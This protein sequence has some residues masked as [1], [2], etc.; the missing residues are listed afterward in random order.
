MHSYKSFSITIG[1]IFILFL[2]N[3]VWAQTIFKGQVINEK[4]LAPLPGAHVVVTGTTEGTITNY[5]G[6]YKLQPSTKRDSITVSFV[7]FLSKTKKLQ[8]DMVI[9]LQPSE[10]ELDK[11][12]V[13]ASR[14][15]QER[16][17]APIAISTISEKTINETKPTTPREVLNKVSGVYMVDLGNEQHSMGMRQPLSY[18]SMFLYLEDGIPIRPTGIFNH[19]ALIEMNMASTSRMEVIKGP[20]SSLYGSEAIGGAI[21]F[22]THRPT[23]DPE[24][25]AQLQGNNLNYKRADLKVSDSWGKVG[26]VAS[27]YYANRTE[28]PRD[29]S[30]FDKLALTIRADW[31][32]TDKTVWTNSLSYIDYKTDM[33]GGVDSTNFFSQDFTS[34]QTFTYRK[35]DALRLRSTVDQFWNPSSKTSITGIYRDNAM[36]QNPHYRIKDDYKPWS[37]TGDPTLA[38]GEENLNSFQSLGVIAQHREQLEFLNTEWITGVSID[39]SPND[40][41]A[42]YI[43]IDKNSEGIYTNYMKTDSLLTKYSID[44]MNTAAYTHLKITPIE[45]LK[46]IASLRYDRIDYDYDNHLNP[47]A[48]SGAPDEKNNFDQ[49]TPKVGLTYDLGNKIG[50]YSN[51]SVGF[52]PPEVSELYRGVKVPTLEPSTYSNYELGGWLSFAKNKGY[53]DLSIYQ[54]NGMNEIIS[55]KQ[56]DGSTEKENAGETRH[57]GVEYTIRYAPIDEV[58]FRVSGANAE[59]EFI[60]FVEEGNDYSGNLM[61]TAPSF[62]ANSEVIYRPEFLDGAHV[63]LEWQHMSEYYMDPANT[64]KYPGFDVFNLRLGYEVSGIEFW[65]HTLNMTDKNYATIVNKSAWGKSYRVGQPRTFTIGINYNFGGG[66]D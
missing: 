38:H 61:S 18:D 21:N 16:S 63:G 8:K 33:T 44:L 37:D 32:V 60:D 56:P 26:V 14:D 31:H 41:K 10:T 36:G 54:L 64:E 48:F 25:Q 29:H 51:Y 58:S 27:G 47:T 13:T 55:V 35:V 65:V 22:I 49:V 45:K 43:Q 4:T 59:H 9:P 53:M 23:R 62:I 2:T 7:G 5:N 57:R 66:T 6:E 15:R 39:Y 46:I 34:L 17:D 3:S 30:D 52:S 28:G 24:F 50:V 42:N 11:I 40:Y 19:N 12:V 20:A 1:I